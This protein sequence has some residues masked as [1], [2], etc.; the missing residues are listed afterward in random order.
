MAYAKTDDGVD[1]YYEAEGDGPAIVF[2]HEFAADL[3]SWSRQRA[4]FQG[5]HRCLAF[6]ARGYPPSV[7]PAD[8]ASYSQAR[9][10]ADVLAV[11]DHAGI[12]QAHVVG[13][14]MGG[15]AALMLG[16]DHPD[17]ALS[18][19]VAGAGYGAEPDQRDRFREEAR[20]S[21]EFLSKHGAAAFAQRYMSGPTRIP[22]KRADPEGFEKFCARMAG[23]SAL[24]LANTQLGVQRERPSLYALRERLAGYRVPALIVNGDEDWPCLLPGVMLKRVMPT[25]ALV[26]LPNCGHTINEEAPDALNRALEGF[27]TQIA[28]GRWPVRDPAAMADTIT[29]MNAPAAGS[30]P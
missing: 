12:A 8:P 5:R 2:V 17:R 30:Q 3:N 28:E 1:L 14:S 4:H 29:G 23:L 9:A 24:G 19:C 18:V 25:A 7:V 6:N 21:A 10:V 26:V 13:L 22:Y 27:Y 20:G 11:M 16:L 15:F